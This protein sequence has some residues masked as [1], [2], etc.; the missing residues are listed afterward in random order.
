MSL[1]KRLKVLSKRASKMSCEITH[2]S[3]LQGNTQAWRTALMSKVLD[4]TP[5]A[6]QFQLGKLH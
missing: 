3:S 4:E 1:I 2:D 6:S 5:P